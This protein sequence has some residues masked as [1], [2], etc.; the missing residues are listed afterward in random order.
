MI[1]YTSDGGYIWTSPRAIIADGKNHWD[2]GLV[3]LANGHILA[4]ETYEGFQ[5]TEPGRIRS[6][7]STDGGLTWGVPQVI[8][9][10]ENEES[11]PKGFQDSTG[12]LW[13]GF[14]R[15]KLSGDLSVDIVKSSDNGYTYPEHYVMWENPGVVE[16]F[17]FIGTQSPGQNVTILFFADYAYNM[18]SWDGGWTFQGPYRLSDTPWVIDPQF[19]V[20][21]RGPI[22]TYTATGRHI[23][24]RYDWTDYCQ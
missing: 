11:F 22:F 4:L 21:C 19:S 20:G 3:V 17:S 16:A 24:K 13:I 5:G 23:A 15:Q 7:R 9:H 1:T 10:G 12:R 2:S 8:W 14:K 6:I 18:D